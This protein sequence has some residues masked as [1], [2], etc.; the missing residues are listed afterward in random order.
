M[1]MKQCSAGFTAELET[2]RTVRL[3]AISLKSTFRFM[4]IIFRSSGVKMVSSSVFSVPKTQVAVLTG[5]WEK[6]RQQDT[7]KQ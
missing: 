4:A 3:V 1:L 2:K 7:A 5:S 6:L